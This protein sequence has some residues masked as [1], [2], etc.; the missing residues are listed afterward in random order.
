MQYRSI[1]SL[2]K[3]ISETD[4][5][6]RLLRYVCVGETF[7]NAQLVRDGWAEAVAYPPDTKYADM[8][9]EL[10][11][12]AREQNIGCWPSGVWGEMPP[13]QPASGGSGGAVCD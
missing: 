8:F 13:V 6:D 12:Q 1:R 11:D 9:R 4:R 2:V 7:V 5:Y 10:Q 3:D